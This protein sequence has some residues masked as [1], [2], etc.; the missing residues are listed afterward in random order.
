[1][2]RIS[3]EAM[4]MEMA[5]SAAKR[6][7]CSRLNVGALVVMENSPISV[8]WNGAAAG[9]PH[10]AGN[11]CPGMVPGKC[12]S[13]HAESNALGKASSIIKAGTEVDLYVTHSPCELCSLVIQ[14]SDLHIG[15]ILFEIPYRST[16]HLGMFSRPY[17]DP[18]LGQGTSEVFQ[19]VTGIYE[20][21]PAGYI[22]EYFS[23]EVVEVI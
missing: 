5:R 19:R 6:S 16:Q 15:R 23:R 22:V 9:E 4:F 14:Q 10:C 3:R 12:P 17:P 20:V 8:G 2:G 18:R 7:T 1:M 21:T 11:D 13:L